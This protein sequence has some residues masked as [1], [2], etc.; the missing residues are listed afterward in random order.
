MAKTKTVTTDVA[1]VSLMALIEDAKAQG[2]L[3]GTRLK[4][5][6][7]DQQPTDEQIMEF[8]AELDMES[9]AELEEVFPLPDAFYE[10]AG[11]EKDYFT[12]AA[13]VGKEA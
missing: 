13:E 6:Y 4:Q 8:V 9:F 3:S 1:T 2:L 11:I 5:I 10:K 7:F 12:P